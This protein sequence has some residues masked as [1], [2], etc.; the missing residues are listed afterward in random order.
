[1]FDIRHSDTKFLRPQPL[2]D[3][4]PGFATGATHTAIAHRRHADRDENPVARCLL[5]TYRMTG[6]FDFKKSSPP[7]ETLH[8]VLTENLHLRIT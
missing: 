5:L 8:W 2:P 3:P 7:T 4:N 6:P 1:M